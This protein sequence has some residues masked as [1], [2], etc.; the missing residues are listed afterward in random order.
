MLYLS[1][2]TYI[3]Y[4]L[5]IMFDIL[6]F[7]FNVSSIMFSKIF[8][9]M[10]KKYVIKIRRTIIV[11]VFIGKFNK[12]INLFLVLIIIELCRLSKSM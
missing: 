11:Y 1:V 10:L 4:Y 7:I 3:T 6:F 9:F 2:I 5:C 8:F 12:T